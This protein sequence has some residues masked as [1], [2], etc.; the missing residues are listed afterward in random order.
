MEYKE[1]SKIYTY[2]F[3]L[4]GIIAS[5]I[6]FTIFLLGYDNVIPTYGWVLMWGVIVV[7]FTIIAWSYFGTKKS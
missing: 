7:L 5:L 2:G 4:G 6:V 1:W 3:I